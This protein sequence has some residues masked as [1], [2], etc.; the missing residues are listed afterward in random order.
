MPYSVLWFL[1][2]VE[3]TRQN[4]NNNKRTKRTTRKI[5]KPSSASALSKVGVTLASRFGLPL[6]E[7]TT[8]KR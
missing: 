3:G 5:N 7:K 2:L 4:H 1:Q 6:M 8:A